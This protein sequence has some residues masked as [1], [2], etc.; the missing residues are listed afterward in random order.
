MDIGEILSSLSDEDMEKIRSAAN[1]IMGENTMQSNGKSD[2][3]SVA[4]TELLS[5][6][7]RIS[8]AF[9]QDDERTALVK[10][11]KP[12]LSEQ[13]QQKADEVIKILRLISIVPLLRDSG[14]LK[15]LL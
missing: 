11:L 8:N 14:L 1:A 12:M 6:I 2:L 10:A 5:G 4:D 9:S 7:S 15:G 3:S 13:K